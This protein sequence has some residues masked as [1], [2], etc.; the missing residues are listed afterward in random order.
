MSNVACVHDDVRLAQLIC[1]R[2]QNA[3]ISYFTH[4]IPALDNVTEKK[5]DLIVV[6]LFLAPGLE[7]IDFTGPSKYSND[8][9]TQAFIEREIR[10]K[11]AAYWKM[12][13]YVISEARRATVNNE[14]PILALHDTD[15]FARY[16]NIWPGFNENL[17]KEANTQGATEVVPWTEIQDI[18]SALRKYL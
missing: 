16:D 17:L 5:Y 11:T 9:A 13:T 10:G 4:A 7:G 12:A 14:T 8:T 6:D 15:R 3:K 1:S 18:R 2:L